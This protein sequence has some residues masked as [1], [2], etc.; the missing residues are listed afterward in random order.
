MSA[1]LVRRI[2]EQQINGK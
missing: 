1:T 2:K